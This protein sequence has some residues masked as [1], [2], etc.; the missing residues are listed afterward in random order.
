MSKCINCN[1][2]LNESQYKKG[3]TYKSCPKCSVADGK[4]HVFYPYPSDFGETEKRITKNNPNG[5][6]SYCQNCRG[7][8]PVKHTGYKKCSKI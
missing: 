1:K 4:E 3:E 2:K 5:A 8:R 6:Q 7:N